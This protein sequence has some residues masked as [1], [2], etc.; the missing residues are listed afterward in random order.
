MKLFNS[1]DSSA[2]VET[3]LC[4]GRVRHCGWNFSFFRVSTQGLKSAQSC[5]HRVTEA[6]CKGVK[7]PQLQADRLPPYSADI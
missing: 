4:V 6:L 7:R 2:G 1:W 3:R 5:I